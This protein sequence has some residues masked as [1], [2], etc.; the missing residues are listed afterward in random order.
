MRYVIQR[1][2]FLRVDRTALMIPTILAAMIPVS[3]IV[4]RSYVMT[5][6]PRLFSERIFFAIST[7]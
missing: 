2:H 3:P 1:L 5:Y 4:V 6:F 7:S